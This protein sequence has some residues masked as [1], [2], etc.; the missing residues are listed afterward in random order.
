MPWLP[1]VSAAVTHLAVRA[2]PDPLSAIAEHALI[3]L[4]PS[5]K[6]TV[7]VGTLPVTVAVKV[8]LL[9]PVDGVSE[10]VTPALLVTLLTT[11]D[12]VVL[13]E[14]AFVASPL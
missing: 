10:V 6:L 9:P 5:L 11:C 14:A 7:P 1:T 8:T 13:V 2:L 3:E 12:N 4:A